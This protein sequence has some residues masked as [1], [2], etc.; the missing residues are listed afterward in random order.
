MKSYWFKAIYVL[1]F[2]I[3]IYL[4]IAVGIE[5]EWFASIRYT[6]SQINSTKLSSIQQHNTP[7]RLR[8]TIPDLD[9]NSQR[10]LLIGDSMAYSLMRR[11]HNYCR[12]NGHEFQT[13]SWVSGTTRWFA[14]TD[15]LDYYLREINPSLVI[16][17]IGSNELFVT[18][19]YDRI[20]YVEKIL[21]KMGSIPNLWV[22]PPNWAKDSGINKMLMKRLGYRGYF[23]SAKLQ[24]ERKEGDVAHPNRSSSAMWADSVASWIV[25][26]SYYPIRL[27]KPLLPD[28]EELECI[29]LNPM[30]NF[31]AYEL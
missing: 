17:V 29:K 22:G 14:L 18:D 2:A 6:I 3:L 24:Y 27:Q 30:K 15:T 31:T 13:V 1:I 7:T 21:Q 10:V 28:E 20:V 23:L 25:E 12:Q 4:F 26:T 19:I 5:R 9:T 8:D 11:F 16:F